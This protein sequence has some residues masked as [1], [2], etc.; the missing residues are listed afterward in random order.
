[1]DSPGPS[2]AGHDDNL[3]RGTRWRRADLLLPLEGDV[4]NWCPLETGQII[5]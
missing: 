2:L 5:K 3:S 4:F 1:M